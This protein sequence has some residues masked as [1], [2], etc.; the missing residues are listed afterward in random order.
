M[1]ENLGLTDNL[2]EDDSFGLFFLSL[3]GV[4]SCDIG[5]DLLEGLLGRCKGV[6]F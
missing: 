1:T 3:V 6:G 2:F 4:G 5:E